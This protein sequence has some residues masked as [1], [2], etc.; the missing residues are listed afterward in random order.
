VSEPRSCQTK[1][2]NIGIY[3]SS[4]SKDCW[5]GIRIMCP[6]RATHNVRKCRFTPLSTIFQLYH[7]GLERR[8]KTFITQSYGTR[9]TLMITYNA[10]I[11]SVIDPSIVL[12]LFVLFFILVIVCA[13]T[14]WV[15]ANLCRLL[16]VVYLY[17]HWKSNYQERIGS[18]PINM[19]NPTTFMYLSQ[20]MTWIS[21][22]IWHYLCLC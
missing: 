21:N 6:C 10:S 16:S 1:D 2:H 14:F 15:E 3:C 12:S 5:L 13:W 4:K 9:T 7:G 19:F 17:C 11:W 22:A 20:T 8:T 18:D